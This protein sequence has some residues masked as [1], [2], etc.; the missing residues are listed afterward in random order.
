MFQYLK[1]HHF[2][3]SNPYRGIYY[4]LNGV[5]FPTQ[6]IVTKELD[7]DSHT[8]LKSLSNRLKKQEMEQLLRH[9]DTLSHK[10]DKRLADA[11]LEVSIRANKQTVEELRGDKSM[12]E[13]L[14]EVFEPEIQ[15][16]KAQA[17]KEVT[18]QVVKNVTDQVTKEITDQVTRFEA[19]G[20]ALRML[21]SGK[22]S[23]EE[24]QKY[25]PR[26]SIHD[27]ESLREELPA[28]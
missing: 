3:L 5:L 1:K 16:M 19:R 9:I 6:I 13:V 10:F 23:P 12:Y 2:K 25:I 27:I 28:L 21:Q 15:Q 22:F 26:L 17:L 11:V 4:V 8:W 7:Y 14:F 24:I 20:T 18:D